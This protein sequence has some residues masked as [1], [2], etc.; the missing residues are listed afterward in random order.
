MTKLVTVMCVCSFAGAALGAYVGSLLEE[1]QSIPRHT[2]GLFTAVGV[3]A[4]VAIGYWTL[5]RR[6]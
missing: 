1:N 5:L 4:F 3:L 6:K 2:G